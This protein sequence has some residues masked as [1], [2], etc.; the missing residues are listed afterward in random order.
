LE[1][2]QYWAEFASEKHAYPVLYILYEGVGASGT[3]GVA[4]LSRQFLSDPQYADQ[5]NSFFAH[6]FYHT[7]GIPDAYGENS[8]AYSSDLMGLGRFLPLAHT[9]L[10][11]ATLKELGL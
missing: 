4:L 10:D 5:N 8:H 9:Y 6:E 11:R 7:V 1:G 3:D 2:D